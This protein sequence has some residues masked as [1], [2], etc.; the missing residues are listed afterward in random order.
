MATEA[1]T[2]PASPSTGDRKSQ[3]IDALLELAAERA[4]EDITIGDIARRAGVSLSQFRE[5]FPS[6]GAVLGA[7]TRRT[8][9]LV[10]DGTSDDLLGEPAKDRLFDVLMRRLD[11]MAPYKR[12]LEGILEWVRREPLAAAALNRE[13]MNSMRF[14]LEAAEIDAEGTVGA[15]KLQGLVLAWAR[16]LEVWFRDDDPGLARTMA[17]LDRELARGGKIVARVEDLNR[18][19]SPFR[20]VIRAMFDARRRF[21]GRVRERARRHDDDGDDSAAA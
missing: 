6:K 21:D 12:G 4:F 18:L 16:V 10:L 5:A 11:A 17:A 8:D 9:K 20:S 3:I 14:M 7:F 19:A 1:P 2:T 15:V 13:V